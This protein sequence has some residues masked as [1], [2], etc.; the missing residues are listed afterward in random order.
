M[1]SYRR[2][3]SQLCSYENLELAFKRARKGKTTKQYVIEFEANLEDNLKQLGYEL[4][5]FTYSP[6]PLTIFI[7]KDPKTRKISAS[8]FRDRVV[9]H[10]LCNIIAPIFEKDFIYD[11]F[12]NR[13][14]KGTHPAIRRF[15]KFIRKAN[16]GYST[17]TQQINENTVGGYVLKADIRRYF[18]SVN[19]EI[20]LNMIQYKVEDKRIIWLIKTILKNHK[21]LI[22]DRGMP[23]GNLTSQ[24]FA[25]VYLHELDLFVKHKL[26]AE[27]Y[28][29]YVD[30]FVIL[31]RN[32]RVLEKWKNEIDGFLKEKLKI[33][34]HPEKSRI[35]PLKRGITFLGFRIFPKYRLLKKSN[36]IRI[37]KRLDKFKQKYEKGEMNRAEVVKSLEGWLAYAGFANSYN[38][39]KKVMARFNQHDRRDPAASCAVYL[40]RS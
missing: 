29:R 40:I 2:L 17:H 28:I 38:L 22:T 24:F 10:A 16:F 34:L 9:H 4:E 1:K 35:I 18:D 36:T 12:A 13:K 30:D 3:Y 11:S 26:K 33:E 8:H 27:Y 15:E 7:V 19:H 23:L 5:N 37:W 31:H 14:D 32:R 6:S 21:T 25:N 39:R 20:L